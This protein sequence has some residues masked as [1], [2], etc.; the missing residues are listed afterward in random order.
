MHSITVLVGLLFVTASAG[1][2]L[3]EHSGRTSALWKRAQGNEQALLSYDWDAAVNR[4]LDSISIEDIHGE[5]GAK[6]SA[7]LPISLYSFLGIPIYRTNIAIG[8][9]NQAFRVILDLAYGGLAVRSVDCDPRDCKIG[10]T[11]NGTRS[12]SNEELDERFCLA[13]PA[14][15]ACGNIIRDTL[16]L[17]SVNIENTTFGDVDVFYG[18]NIFYYVLAQISDGYV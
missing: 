12:L 8:T 1:F 13:L 18:E 17:I 4:S 11:Y 14:H 3:D 15:T 6:H 5:T 9:P 10:F 7:T 2:L 16:H